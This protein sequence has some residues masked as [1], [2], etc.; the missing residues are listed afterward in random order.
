LFSTEQHDPDA[1][2]GAIWQMDVFVDAPLRDRFVQNSLDPTIEVNPENPIDA[3]YPLPANK[4]APDMCIWHRSPY[5]LDG[6]ADN[7]RER[8]GHDFMLPYW[9]GRYYG[10]IGPNW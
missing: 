10:Y 9:M 7:G 5:R 1:L 6:G 4:K 3:L 2:M 8:S